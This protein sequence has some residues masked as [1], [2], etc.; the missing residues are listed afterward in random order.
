V[1]VVPLFAPPDGETVALPGRGVRVASS[2]TEDDPEVLG[3]WLAV[4]VED[5][6]VA[7]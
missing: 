2:D 4:G 5:N 7:L 6:V 3:L 1:A